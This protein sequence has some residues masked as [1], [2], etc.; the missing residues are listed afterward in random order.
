MVYVSV[1]G[2]TLRRWWHA[3]RFWWHAVPSFRQAQRAPGNLKAETRAVDGVKHTLTVWSDRDAM[4][5]YLVT[6]PHLKA[7]RSF[8]SIAVGKTLGYWAEAMPSWDEA[9]AR[10]RAEAREV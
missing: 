3:P 7:M 4:R 8:R 1:T 2:L 6:G 5:T 10:W 9:L